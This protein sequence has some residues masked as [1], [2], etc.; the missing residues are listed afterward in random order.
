MLQRL[1]SMQSIAVES[2]GQ[3]RVVMAGK[4]R[5]GGREGGEGANEGTEGG[6]REDGRVDI[7]ASVCEVC[8]SL[9]L[10]CGFSTA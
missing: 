1:W 8:Y 7:L 6:R 3:A 9:S 10:A 4:G 2:P 5:G